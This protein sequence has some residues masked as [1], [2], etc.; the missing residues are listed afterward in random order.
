MRS[1]FHVCSSPILQYF[2]HFRVARS[3]PHR[4]CA[5]GKGLTQA[6]AEDFFVH[7]SVDKFE[8]NSP[9]ICT[10]CRCHSAAKSGRTCVCASLN[11]AARC[12]ALHWRVAL[13]SLMRVH[14]IRD[15]PHPLCPRAA[16]SVPLPTSAPPSTHWRTCRPPS[17]PPRASLSAHKSAPE[18]LAA[19][20]AR[21][22]R[23]Y[24]IR[25][26]PLMRSSPSSARAA[27]PSAY[28]PRAEG[29]LPP[30]PYRRPGRPSS[31]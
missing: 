13:V 27:P 20:P 21:L 1:T 5:I 3:L 18:P 30:P 10:R 8:C 14:R 16:S 26:R 28:R 25:S 7:K 15:S 4:V 6:E 9:R 17:N 24:P 22:M 2:L 11:L 29:P 23:P 19:V 31:T 12:H